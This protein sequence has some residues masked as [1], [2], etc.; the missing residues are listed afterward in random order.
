[1]DPIDY[2]DKYAAVV[3]EDTADIDMKDIMDEFLSHMKEGQ[4]ILDMGCGSGRDSRTFYEMGY[5]VTAMDGSE[6]MCKLAEIETDM[7]VLHM[8]YEQMCFEE[9][10]DG[11]WA[12]AA[13]FHIQKKALGSILQKMVR[14][15]DF[16]G[17]MYTSFLEGDMEGF[18]GNLYFSEYTEVEI[19]ELF[20]GIENVNLVKIWITQEPG[21]EDS[22]VRWINVLAEKKQKED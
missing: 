6:E 7:E 10:F 4:S 1:M 19:Y 16:G 15:L 21:S 8:T 13:L 18:R 20:S 3:Y 11:I 17:I 22:D 9:A 5:D 12:C 2:Y 14:S